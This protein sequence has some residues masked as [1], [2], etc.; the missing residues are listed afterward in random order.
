MAPKPVDITGQT[1]GNLT[2][3]RRVSGGA[4]GSRWLFRCSCGTEKELIASEVKRGRTKSCGCSSSRAFDITG[5]RFGRLVAIKRVADRVL[6]KRA[7]VT[8]LFQCDCGVTKEIDGNNVKAGKTSSCG[9][10]AVELRRKTKSPSIGGQRFGRLV[11]VERINAQKWLFRCDCG[12]SYEGWRAP[13][14]QGKVQS[15]G[16][17]HK[18]SITGIK[19]DLTGRRFGM[20]TAVRPVRSARGNWHWVFQCECGAEKICDPGNV[21]SGRTASC[22][23]AQQPGGDC[24][25]G[26]LGGYFR[27]PDRDCSL[28]LHSLKNYPE[29]YK[30]GIDATGLRANDPEYGRLL[31]SFRLPRAEAWAVEQVVLAATRQWWRPP[32]E[33]VDVKWAGYTELRSAREPVLAETMCNLVAEVRSKGLD[34]FILDNFRLQPSHK[35]KIKNRLRIKT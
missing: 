35:R 14:L 34:K 20:L 7:R 13:V 9:C 6:G 19:D 4:N 2:A 18:E 29:Q 27:C 31:L 30:V 17:L 12:S 15:C 5:Q 25:G 16:C 11:A 21:K 32:L 33:L 8:W 22:G 1:Y 23:C 10:I 26:Y 3:V 24:I 28:Y